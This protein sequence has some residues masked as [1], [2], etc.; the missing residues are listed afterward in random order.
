MKKITGQ[1]PV[2]IIGCI[3]FL[4]LPILF[5]PD[6]SW[7]LDFF[8]IRAFQRD[9]FA[10]ALLLAFFYANY[11]YLLPHFY[12]RQKILLYIAGI[13]TAYC[14]VTFLPGLLIPAKQM[15]PLNPNAGM[16]GMPGP[17]PYGL[18]FGFLRDLG[19]YIFQFVIILS[20]SV[21]YR[22]N[23]RLKQAE[24][25]RADAE[26]SYLKAQ[27]NPHFLFNTLNSIYASAI[28][29]NADN[30]AD[31][32]VKLSGMMRYVITE[33]EQATV[34]LEQEINYITDYIE[35]QQ[36]RLG[37]TLALNY[38]VNGDP[39]G[40]RIAPLILISFIENAFKYGVNPEE[41]S[42]IDITIDIIKESLDMTV[43][44]IV[45]TNRSQG[46]VKSGVGLENTINRLKLHYPYGH[47]LSILEEAGIFTVRLKINL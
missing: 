30:T 1:L 35:L 16:P 40:K 27:I 4:S 10:Y 12:F 21:M 26:L 22:T 11:F 29:E 46:P 15:M 25:E 33:A 42:K 45:V 14:M 18:P 31:A 20:L 44:N 13:L 19:H 37:N 39:D 38:Q 3:A 47:T 17:R 8:K 2:H 9:F 32:I 43:T 36:I 6:V 28:S 24:K 5:S 41:R 34:S 23:Q 7:S